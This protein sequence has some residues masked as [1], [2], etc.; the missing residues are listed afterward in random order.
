MRR[1]RAEVIGWAAAACLAGA[2]VLT[3]LGAH[4]GWVRLSWTAET[5]FT[6]VRSGCVASGQ[7][8]R[9]PVTVSGASGVLTIEGLPDTGRCYFAPN[10]GAQDEW[11]YDFDALTGA[12]AVPGAVRNLNVATAP[13]PPATAKALLTITWT[14]VQNVIG[15]LVVR[16]QG[17]VEI[18][19]TVITLPDQA[20]D[21]IT[22]TA[23]SPTNL[24]VNGDGITSRTATLTARV[25][26]GASINGEIDIDTR[27]PTGISATV[28]FVGLPA[29]TLPLTATATGYTATFTP[30]GTATV[31]DVGGDVR[32]ALT[33]FDD[34][35]ML[36]WSGGRDC[37]HA[38]TPDYAYWDNDHRDVLGELEIA[39]AV[40]T[41]ITLLCD[42]GRATVAYV[43]RTP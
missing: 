23:V 15:D 14:S 4:A 28:T 6:A 36:N 35:G 18:Q 11:V 40:A 21:Y 8:E 7:Y 31:V 13:T 22:G 1:P 32:L 29:I 17:T 34:Y 37:V 2:Y 9:A 16:N 19:R 27:M 12:R 39:P 38:S 20:I 41:E 10:G 42:N 25:A 24:N 3:A 43:P 30:P 5:G 26:P 33:S